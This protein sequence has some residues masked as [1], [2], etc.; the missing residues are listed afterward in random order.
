MGF[1]LTEKII[2]GVTALIVAG[3]VYVL[4]FTEADCPKGEK[5]TVT[6]WTTGYKGQGAPLYGCRPE[7]HG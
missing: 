5:V 1:D 4:F 2:F 6:G 3:L 7:H